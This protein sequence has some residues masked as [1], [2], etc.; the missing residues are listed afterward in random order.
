MVT[1]SDSVVVQIEDLVRDLDAGEDNPRTLI[2][3]HLEAARYYLL[4]SMQAEYYLNLGLAENVLS[5][6]EDKDLRA[7]IETFLRSQ[8]QE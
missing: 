2:R 5:E 1:S 8:R 6:I 4:G 7:R 3:E